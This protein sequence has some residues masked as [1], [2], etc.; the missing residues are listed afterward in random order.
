VRTTVVEMLASLGYRVLKAKDAQSALA[1][2]E[3][4][5]PI[6]LLFTDVVMPGPLRSTE[7]ARKARERQ[8]GIAVLFTSGYTDNAIVHAGRLDEGVELL[9]KPYSQEAL[10]RKIQHALRLQYARPE[11]AVTLQ[12]ED[13]QTVRYVDRQ[14]NETFDAIRDLR[15]LFVEDDELVRVSTAELLRTFGLEVAETESAAQA[16]QMLGERDFDVLLTDIGLAGVSG[17][18]LAID[19]AARQPR[20]RVI[21]VTGSDAAL[22]PQQQTQLQNVAQLRKPYDPL[23]LVNALRACVE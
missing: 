9:S 17:V 3:S 6:H 5:V 4:G 16:S 11:D 2:V 21:F 19:A 10:A 14:N 20:M 7:L 13:S 8:P 15:I 23:D 1:I 12:A 22:S 18:D